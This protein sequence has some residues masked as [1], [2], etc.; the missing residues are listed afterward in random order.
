[1]TQK[2]LQRHNVQS[3]GLQGKNVQIHVKG[4][5]SIGEVNGEASL[6]PSQ[7]TSQAQELTL[8]LVALADRAEALSTGGISEGLNSWT[9]NSCKL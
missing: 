5:K 1:M 6:L 7:G 2:M 9:T 8:P 3:N 4:F